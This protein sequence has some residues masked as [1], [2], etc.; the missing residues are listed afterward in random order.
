MLVKDEVSLLIELS[1]YNLNLIIF[2]NSIKFLNS[3]LN[4]RSPSYCFDLITSF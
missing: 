4:V 1:L 2:Q 3:S